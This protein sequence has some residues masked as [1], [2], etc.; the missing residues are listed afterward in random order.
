M[1]SKKEKGSVNAV[2]SKSSPLGAH[3]HDDE[4][5]AK[6]Y[7]FDNFGFDIDAVKSTGSS[8]IKEEF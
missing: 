6:K 7:I 2:R 5:K 4:V 3:S 8:Q 1:L